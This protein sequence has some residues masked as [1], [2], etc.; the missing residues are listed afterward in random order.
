[1]VHYQ[2]LLCLDTYDMDGLYRYKQL[3]KLNYV[4]HHV[5]SYKS[6]AGLSPLFSMNMVCYHDFETLV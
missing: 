5:L 2:V 4:F 3:C 1:M 6:A